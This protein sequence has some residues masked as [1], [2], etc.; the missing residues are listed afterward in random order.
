M[1]ELSLILVAMTA[2]MEAAFRS[3]FA[4]WPEDGAYRRLPGVRHGLWQSRAG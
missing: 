4:Q 3:N 1:S 2:E